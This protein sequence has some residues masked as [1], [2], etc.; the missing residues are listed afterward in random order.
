MFISF[1]F[2]KGGG[3]RTI[4]AAG[5]SVDKTT[6]QRA[7]STCVSPSSMDMTIGVILVFGARF[8]H[9][10]GSLGGDGIVVGPHGGS[11]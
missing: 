6:Q 2:L 8:P 3:Q 10:K 9:S 11:A 7:S 1:L 5:R 4:K